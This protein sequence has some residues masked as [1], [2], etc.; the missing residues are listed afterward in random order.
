MQPVVLEK[1]KIHSYLKSD[2]FVHSG[3]FYPNFLIGTIVREILLL[4]D[5]LQMATR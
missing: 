1:K 4:K 2:P 3:Y 5:I